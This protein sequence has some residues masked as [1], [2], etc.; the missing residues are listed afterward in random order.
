MTKIVLITGTSTG[1]GISIAVQAAQAGH[2]VYATMLNLAKREALDAAAEAAGVTL[3]VLPLDVQDTDSVDAAV[4]QVIEE[5]G[6]IDTL[7]NNAGMGYARSLEQAE[8]A[9]VARIL[10][11]NYMGVVRCTKAVMPHMRKA[12]SGHVINISS[13][14]GLVGQP[15]NEVYCGAKFAVEGLTEAMASYITPS[16]GINFTAVESGGIA[17]E[18]ANT[19]LKQIADTGGM[20]EDE[21]LPILQKYVANAQSRQGSGVYQTADEVAAVVLREMESEA[22]ALR[23]R[24][25]DWGEEFTRLK[26]GL[27]PDGRKLQRMVTEQILG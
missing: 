20:L 16:F 4:A 18:F 24:T 21:Y 8:E 17:S 19:V 23:C 7:V 26:T 6:R 14:G 27:D 10:D 22:P 11:I 25:S 1:L 12:R 2:T 5:Q 3:K 13:V 15:F 9:D